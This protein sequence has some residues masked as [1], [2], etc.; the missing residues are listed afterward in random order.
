LRLLGRET[1]PGHL[2]KLSA[3]S[4][5]DTLIAVVEIGSTCHTRDRAR[6][7]RRIARWERI[8]ENLVDVH[9]R[10]QFVLV[11]VV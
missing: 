7:R 2:E 11:F 4:P 3:D 5:N 10:P 8:V 6:P 9:R 1:Q